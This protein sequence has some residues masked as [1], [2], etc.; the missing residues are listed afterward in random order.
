MELKDLKS[1]IANLQNQ[2]QQLV[3]SMMENRAALLILAKLLVFL[4]VGKTGG[5]GW[6]EGS[7]G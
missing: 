2:V 4:D 7:G 6:K 5:R 3:R 1:Q